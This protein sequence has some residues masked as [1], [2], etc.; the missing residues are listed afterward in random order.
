[1]KKYKDYVTVTLSEQLF[2]FI[3]WETL[4]FVFI[5]DFFWKC[6]GF[7]SGFYKTKPQVSL[8]IKAISD[9]ERAFVVFKEKKI[10]SS[11]P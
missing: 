1:M 8:I 9:Q 4:L 10:V 7:N 6:Y 3:L 11:K 5:L 2:T